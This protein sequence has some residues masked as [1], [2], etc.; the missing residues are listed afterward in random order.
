RFAYASYVAELTDRMSV[1]EDPH[2][3]LY[4]LLVDVLAQIEAGPATSALLRAFELQLLAS[5]GFEPQLD[6][7]NRCRRPWGED[8]RAWIATHHGTVACDACRSAEDATEPV[9]GAVL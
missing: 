4:T 5:A 1:E 6:G 7:C 9:S 3:N 2:H 8:E